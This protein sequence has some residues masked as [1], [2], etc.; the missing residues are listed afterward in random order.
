MTEDNRKRGGKRD[1]FIEY[2]SWTSMI[3]R[4]TKPEHPSYKNYGGRGIKVCE[5]WMVFENF[6]SDVGPKPSRR[7]TIDRIDSDGDYEPKNCRWSTRV[8]QNRNKSDNVWIEHRGERRTAAEWARVL[9]I[10]LS[11]LRYRFRRGLSGEALFSDSDRRTGGL[12]RPANFS[13][14]EENKKLREEL[15]EIG[16]ERDELA[17]KLGMAEAVIEAAKECDHRFGTN[18]SDARWMRFRAALAKYDAK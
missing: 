5:R 11:T 14:L 1:R 4:C 13:V 12:K 10:P 9:G 3:R 16:K 17:F 18:G 7:H 2:G 8:E 15:Q 6:L